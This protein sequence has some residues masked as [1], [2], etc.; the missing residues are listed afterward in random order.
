MIILLTGSTGMVGK[1]ILD[2][3]ASNNFDFICPTRKELDLTNGF[4]VNNYIKKTNPDLIIHAAGRVGGIKVNN[5]NPIS[6][7]V[8][9]IQVGLNVIISAFQ[10]N[11]NRL[12]NLGSSCM[13]P[14]DAINPLIES[15]ILSGKLEPTNEGYALSK[16]VTNRLCNYITEQKSDKNYKTIIPCN[17]FGKFD[18]FNLDSSHLIPAIIRKVDQAIENRSNIEIWGDGQ[19]RREFMYAEDLA[20]A[21]YFIIDNYN[22]IDTTMNIGL[23]YDYSINEYYKKVAE[24]MNYNG[25]FVH[26]NK[27]P[28]GMKQKVVSIEK[29]NKLGWKPIF[30]LEDGLLKTIEYY[31]KFVK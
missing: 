9:N 25:E 22:L 17:L 20:R 12:I 14:K 6:F 1:N 30:N 15:S 26:N 23:G 31:Y 24:L 3:P 18:D 19:S 27:M 29:Q 2:S 7:L 21:I 11:I 8:D 13:Y 4:S 28:S 10:N 16:I 5:S